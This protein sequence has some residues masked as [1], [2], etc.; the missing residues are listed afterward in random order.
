MGPPRDPLARLPHPAPHAPALAIIESRLNTVKITRGAIHILEI[1][2]YHNAGTR[3]HLVAACMVLKHESVSTLRVV[4]YVTLDYVA[5]LRS[6]G[7]KRVEFMD[8]VLLDAINVAPCV[9]L[10][11]GGGN[12]DIVKK[13]IRQ[14]AVPPVLILTAGCGRARSTSWRG[15]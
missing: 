8:R 13:A 15:A 7:A 14:N 2:G 6:V 11:V 9:R 5:S 12:I 10:S 4:P 1:I 3:R